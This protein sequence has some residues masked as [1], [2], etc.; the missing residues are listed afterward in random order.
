MEEAANFV[1]WASGVPRGVVVGRQ[2]GHSPNNGSR[3]R[4]KL[5]RGELFPV[6]IVPDR[7]IGDDRPRPKNESSGFTSISGLVLGPGCKDGGGGS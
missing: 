1:V 7:V 3:E 2:F 6:L 5:I 4:F